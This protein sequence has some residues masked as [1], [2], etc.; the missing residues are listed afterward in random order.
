M[1]LYCCSRRLLGSF[2]QQEQ[3]QEIRLKTQAHMR[4]LRRGLPVRFYP[5]P[6]SMPNIVVLESQFQRMEKAVL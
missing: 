5:I 4:K 6:T 1:V 2:F 3:R